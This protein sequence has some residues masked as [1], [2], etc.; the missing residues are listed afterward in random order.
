MGLAR[1]SSEDWNMF[2]STEPQNSMAWK[3]VR[4]ISNVVVIGSRLKLFTAL[5]NELAA[6]VSSFGTKIQIVAVC[7][8][9]WQNNQVR[10][11]GYLWFLTWQNRLS[12]DLGTDDIGWSGR[13]GPA[14]SEES[15]SIATSAM[16][17]LTWIRIRQ[18]FSY[19]CHGCMQSLQRSA[20][21]GQVLGAA[22]RNPSLL[23]QL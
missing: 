17:T 5:F 1:G 9:R 11:S 10:S 15:G 4:Y 16:F 13:S 6:W 2:F 14:E 12:D 19:Y 20:S 18:A 22:E 8:K 3:K 21:E 23:W 7:I